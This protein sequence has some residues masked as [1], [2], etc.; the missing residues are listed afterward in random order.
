MGLLYSGGLGGG[1][2]FREGLFFFRGLLFEFYGVDVI[3]LARGSCWGN[4]DRVPFL[5]VYGW[6]IL[7]NGFK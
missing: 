3:E 7:N 6:P 2:Y 5:H 4:I 1:V